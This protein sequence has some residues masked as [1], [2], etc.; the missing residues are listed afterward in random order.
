MSHNLIGT[1]ARAILPTRY[2]PDVYLRGLIR[3]RTDLVVM[4]GCFAG[5]VFP[6]EPGREGLWPMLA[7]TYERELAAVVEEIVAAGFE[8]IVNIGA[9]D[10][11]Y[12]VGLARRIRR[13]TVCAFEMDE[14]TRLL[15][16]A[17]ALANGVADRVV[18]KGKCEP[19]DLRECLARGREN[20]VICDV[21]G[22]ESVLLDPSLVPE[23]VDAHV[24]V[25][26]HE[27]QHPGIADLLRARLDGSHQIEQI[28]QEPR[29]ASEYPFRTLYTRLLPDRIVSNAINEW[30]SEKQSWFWMRPRS[31]VLP[32][33]GPK[34]HPPATPPVRPA[35]RALA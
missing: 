22:H 18:T 30:R 10:G 16:Q 2:H 11:Y 32:L 34:S 12:A 27:L 20:L 25:E 4:Q 14:S 28:W 29:S 7:G 15:L 17:M 9:G 24:L 6:Y 33:P 21:E 26:L 5:L 23:L 8:T 19:A 31:G 1:I 35:N 13:A 3:E